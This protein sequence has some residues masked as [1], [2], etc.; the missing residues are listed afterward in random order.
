[1]TDRRLDEGVRLARGG[2]LEKAFQQL[3]LAAG[4]NDPAIAAEALR[5]Q[6]DIHRSRCEWDPALDCARRSGRLAEAADLPDLLAEA[7]N[8]EASVYISQGELGLARQLLL[9]MIG[10]TGNDRI[11]GIALQNLGMVAAEEGRLDEA[12]A[13]FEGALRAFEGV[14]YER[15]AAMALL[16]CGR[17]AVLQERCDD[18]EEICVR[19]E[20]AAR[21]VGDLELVALACLNL[22]ECYLLRGEAAE[23]ERPA[24]E[25]MGY[26]AGVGNEWRRIE[27]LRVFG[28]IH[29]SGADRRSAEACYQRG[30]ELAHGLGAQVEIERLEAKIAGLGSG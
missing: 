7:L 3:G 10:I 24:S 9:R 16:N 1:M 26:F 4:S 30:L 23:A 6:A 27:C 8:A 21:A 17:I 22:A 18:A 20:K 11:R 2:L 12:R 14:G 25:A 13:H 15:G 19:A 28:D 29:R 5:H